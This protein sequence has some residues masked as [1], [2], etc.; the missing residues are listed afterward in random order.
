MGRN[1]LSTQ[2]QA[3]AHR[4]EG[5]ALI[6]NTAILADGSG[7]GHMTGFGWGMMVFWSMVAIAMLAVLV[8]V[9]TRTEP[10]G[11]AGAESSRRTTATEI[12]AE[13]FARGEI[14]EEEYHQRKAALE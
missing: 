14:D 10:R 6:T 13:R 12:L 4:R 7:F 1:Q 8:W 9:L 5:N 3:H 11:S 2:S